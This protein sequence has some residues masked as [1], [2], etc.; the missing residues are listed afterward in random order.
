[1]V[2]HGFEIQAG[3][4]KTFKLVFAVSLLSIQH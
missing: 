4:A 1:V 2:V 3:E